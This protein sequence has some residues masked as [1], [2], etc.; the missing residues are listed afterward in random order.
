MNDLID[1][2]RD[3]LD[4]ADDETCTCPDCDVSTLFG[5]RATIKGLDPRCPIHG[6]PTEERR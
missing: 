1:Y 2:L 5:E 3:K 4:Q 6:S